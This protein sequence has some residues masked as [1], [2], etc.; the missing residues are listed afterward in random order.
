MSSP[1]SVSLPTQT[2]AAVPAGS[3][4]ASSSRPPRSPKAPKPTAEGSKGKGAASEGGAKSDKKSAK[5]DKKAKR[6]ALVAQRGGADA[7]SVGPGPSQPNGSPAASL[8]APSQAAAQPGPQ[9]PQGASRPGLPNVPSHSH[10][11]QPAAAHAP[12]PKRPGLATVETS[13]SEAKWFFSHLPSH[14]PPHTPSALNSTKLHP[15]VIRLGVLMSSGTLRGANARTMGMMAAFKEVIRDYES[16]ESAVLWKDLPGHLSP[17]IAFLEGCRPKGVGGGNAIRWL[18]GEINKLGEQGEGTE[19]EQKQYLIDAIDVYLRDRID[20]A[21]QVIAANAKEKIKPNDIVVV[22]ARSSVVERALIEAWRSM[23]ARDPE[24][25]FSVIVVDSRPLH[26]GRALLAALSEA[27]LPCT[28]TLLPL[29]SP[30][31]PSADL[32]LLGASALHSDGSLYSRAGTAMIAMMAKEARVPVVVCCETYKFGERVVLDGVGA[33]ELGD[34]TG[35]FDIGKAASKKDLGGRNEKD[36]A[37]RSKGV[38][39]LALLYDL[40]PPSLITAVCTE[41]GFIPPSSV[42]TVLGKA[43][44]VA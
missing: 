14:I 17:M 26:E 40:T 38:T 23:R 3:S 36:E 10:P 13:P 20:F 15:L 6:A 19:A 32:V 12:A 28:Y 22:Y 29:L 5:E 7:T 1:S 30:L 42:P 37:A 34:I 2:P 4:S 9:R 8:S 33:N 16:P 41:I 35:F 39:P 18:K 27:G 21:G 25:T 44:G 31:L 24:A 11:N 43:S